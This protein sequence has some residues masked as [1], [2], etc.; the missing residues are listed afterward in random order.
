MTAT[1]PA[2]GAAGESAII[3][4]VEL[5]V[6][7]R[8]LRDGLDPVAALGVPA[9]VMLL[10]PFMPPGL[11]D[12]EV[13][14]RV[15]AIVA[16][17]RS[18]SFALAR[19]E[20]WPSVVWLAPEPDEPFRRLTAALHAEFPDY[21]PYA[22]VHEEVIP[23]LTIVEDPRPEWLAAAERALPQMLPIRDVAREAHVIAQDGDRPWSTLWRLPLGRRG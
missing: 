19:M 9:H 20:R 2:H 11:L 8:R 18:F 4:P 7:A 14:R 3:V 13:R 1:P 5:P 16:T 12:D 17:E 6:A 15:A 22:G 23:H 21:P 10:Y